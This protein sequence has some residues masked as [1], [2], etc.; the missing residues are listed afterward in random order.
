MFLFFSTLIHSA[1][2]N[3][4]VLCIS[5]CTHFSGMFSNGNSCSKGMGMINYLLFTLPM[6]T[7]Y[8]HCNCGSRGR[9][10]RTNQQAPSPSA[11]SSIWPMKTINR[12]W[13]EGGNWEHVIYFPRFLCVGS[14]QADYATPLMVEVPG[15]LSPVT[16]L[17]SSRSQ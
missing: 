1:I 12:K 7:L 9:V 2:I 17:S 5:L 8:T 6:S 16:V 14:Q 13:G 11:S 10:I 3:I 4:S 15:C